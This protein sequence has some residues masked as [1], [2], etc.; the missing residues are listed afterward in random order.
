MDPTTTANKSL[1]EFIVS[2]PSP[3]ISSAIPPRV[4]SSTSIRIAAATVS[5]RPIGKNAWHMDEEGVVHL[6]ASDEHVL[7]PLLFGPDEVEDL[8]DDDMIG[9]FDF[10]L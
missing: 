7:E 2:F 1:E 6:V 10:C 5:P 9:P 8:P 3:R 4:V